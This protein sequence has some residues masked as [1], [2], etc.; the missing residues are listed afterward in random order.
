MADHH[1]FVSLYRGEEGLSEWLQL[2]LLQRG[3][4]PMLCV[5]GDYVSAQ[6]LETTFLYVKTKFYCAF[7]RGAT[8]K[9]L[10]WFLFQG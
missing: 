10:K 2:V 4:L 3:W 9:I 1:N 5:Q 7:A 8:Y 6:L